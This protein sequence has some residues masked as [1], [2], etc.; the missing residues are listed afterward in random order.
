MSN[1]VEVKYC[2]GCERDLPRDAF[3]KMSAAPDG[4]QYRCRECQKRRWDSLPPGVRRNYYKTH[5]ERHREKRRLYAEVERK[6]YPERVRER[7]YRTIYG[8]DLAE[9]EELLAAQGGVCRIC[10]GQNLNQRRLGVDHCHVTGKVRG[11]LC[12]YC[13]SG[14][15]YFK[16]DLDLIIKAYHY[17]MT[18]REEVLTEG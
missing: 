14:I 8:I 10:G 3:S 9:Y 7:S 5:D 13:N 4:L 12:N 6:D 2:R 15:G 16:D 11:L 1:D 17:L 18:S